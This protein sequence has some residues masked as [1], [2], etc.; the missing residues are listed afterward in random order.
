MSP[1]TRNNN[2]CRLNDAFISDL[3]YICSYC[4]DPRKNRFKVNL[5]KARFLFKQ[6]DRGSDKSPLLIVFSDIHTDQ[7]NHD[8][9]SATVRF[10]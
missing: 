1:K 4:G 10:Y 8:I 2:L 6:S 5:T 3:Q 9:L 7:S